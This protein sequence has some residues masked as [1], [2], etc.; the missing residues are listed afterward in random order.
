L[1]NRP[2]IL[3]L[4]LL[5]PASVSR[6]DDG[7]NLE[8][9]VRLALERN[10]R[11]RA[12][13]A[14]LQASQARVSGARAHFLPDLTLVGNYTRRAYQTSREVGGETVILQRYNALSPTATMA[15]NIFDAR[16]FPLYRMARQEREATR[17]SSA[18]DRR[19]LAF[20]AAGAFL[21]A[22]SAEQVSEAAQRRLDFARRSLRDAQARF[23]AQIA[24]SN[25]VTRAELELATAER[26]LTGA[27]GDAQT[28]RLSL[29]Y[30]IDTDVEGPLA[31]PAALLQ[32]AAGPP[33]GGDDLIAQA[34]RQRPDVAAGR[35]RAGALHASAQEPLF[36]VFP[37][38]TLTGQYRGTNETGLNGRHH[39]GNAVL[40]LTWRLYDGGEASASRAERL[41]LARAADLDAQAVERRVA[42]EVRSAL[43]ALA[44]RQAAIRQASVAVDVARKNA[45]QA[46]ELYRQGLASALQ[47]ADANV[48]LFESEVALA[49]ARYG[50]ALAYLDL[51]AARGLHP[52]GEEPAP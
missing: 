6:A 4:A 10:E 14:R 3:F 12:A 26:E 23:E 11:A 17:L 51:R 24:S 46:A 15:L 30:L 33:G 1:R 42:L 19:L 7:L 52:L 35:Q 2:F 45:D 8:K 16:A 9:A 43:V 32:A 27:Q 50:L 28:A 13:E 48:R 34:R 20:D 39:D 31:P 5:L 40:S 22:L 37:S 49:R 25:D 29:S 44:S 18:D 36:R 47:V 38:L 41:A 21:T